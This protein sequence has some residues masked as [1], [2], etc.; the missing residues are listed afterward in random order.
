M[1]NYVGIVR[2]NLRLARARQRLDT[3]ERE[4]VKD[5]WSFVV[6]RDLIELRNIV[7]VASLIVDCAQTR[8]ESRGLHY[9]HDYPERD[10]GHWLRDTVMTRGRRR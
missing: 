3:L 1:W 7:T 5:Y 6:T 10:D 9:T 8:H 4:T 2:S